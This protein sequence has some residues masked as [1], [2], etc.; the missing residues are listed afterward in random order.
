MIE[1][2]ETEELPG[3]MLERG[4]RAR[5]T[6]LLRLGSV[7][8]KL[9]SLRPSGSAVDRALALWGAAAPTVDRARPIVAVGSGSVALA[10]AGWARARG[11]SLHLV[12]HGPLT[13][14][15]KEALAIWGMPTSSVASLAEAQPVVARLVSSG[16]Q[17]LPSLEGGGAAE[18]VRATLG[19][20][21]LRDLES[22]DVAPSI[23]VAPVGA[24]AALAGALLALRTR[25]PALRAIA[26]HAAGPDDVLPDLPVAPEALHLLEAALRS[27]LD[28][29]P[30]ELLP[31][32]RAQ[33]QA[34]RLL[35]ARSHGLC[36]SHGAAA[37]LQIAAEQAAGGA[38]A[39]IHATGEREFSLDP[40]ARSSA[41]PLSA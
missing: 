16:A 20:E 10:G 21:L 17:L 25:W 15:T 3:A 34:A 11:L 39:I 29:M 18:A 22:S 9:E 37:A 41:R 1:S 4:L 7:L 28:L 2:V 23:L 24:S 5:P 40:P 27:P 33:A 13:H 19:V 8:A 31:I 38:I 35:A 12:V 26:L 30:V 32:T 36:A 14:E 6:P